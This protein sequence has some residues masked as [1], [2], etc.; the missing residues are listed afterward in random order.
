MYPYTHVHVYGDMYIYIC[1]YVYIYIGVNILDFEILKEILIFEI[2]SSILNKIL[3]KLKNFNIF[4]SK[5]FRKFQ[6]FIKRFY[7]R[8]N[9]IFSI[10]PKISIK[11]S[12]FSYFNIL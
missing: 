1:I 4:K 7:F 5:N 8:E 2:K 10:F 6:Y 11:N 9:L 3:I 12:F